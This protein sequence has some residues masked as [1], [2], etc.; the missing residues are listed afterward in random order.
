MW[1]GD[2]VWVGRRTGLCGVLAT[3]IISL[4]FTSSA[5]AAPASGAKPYSNSKVEG[6]LAVGALGVLSAALIPDDQS[7]G[8][9]TVNDPTVT[10]AT[11]VPGQAVT[12]RDTATD[13]N[14]TNGTYLTYTWDFGDGTPDVTTT[15]AISSVS[16]TFATTGTYTVTVNVSDS[17]DGGDEVDAAP[18]PCGGGGGCGG[19]DN[20]DGDTL[21]V[22]V[23]TA[24]TGDG[25]A[26]NDLP[27][28]YANSLAPNDDGYSDDAVPIGFPINFFGETET[29]LYVNENGNVTFD[30]QQSAFSP[31]PL[32]T[33]DQPIIAPFWSDVDTSDPVTPDG[34]VSSL[35]TYGQT[36]YDGNPAFCV[37]WGGENGAVGYYDQH[38][39]K[40]NRYELLIVDR[41]DVA[42]GD[43]DIYFN[44]DQLQYETGDASGG[45]D[46]LGGDGARA[47]YANG[48][49]SYELPGSGSDGVFLTGDPDDLVANSNDGVAGQYVYPFRGGNGL[50]STTL[51]GTVTDS[52][53][54]DVE[55][56]VEA[57]PTGGGACDTAWSNADGSYSIDAQP[58]TAYTVTAYPL[59]NDTSDS[60]SAAT[61]VTTPSAGDIEQELQLEAPLLPPTNVTIQSS[62]TATQGGVPVVDWQDST[63]LTVVGCAGGSASYSITAVNPYDGES[64]TVTGALTPGAVSG[65][66]TTYSASIPQLYPLHG[67]AQVTIT[68]TGCADP[69]ADQ[70]SAFDIYIDPSGMVVNTSGQPIADATVTLLTASSAAGP[71]YPVP[72][73]SAVMSP[74]NRVNPFTTDATGSYGWDTLAG[75]YEVEATAPGCYAPGNPSSP[76]VYS[77]VL[78]VPPAATGVTLTLDCAPLPPSTPA[79]APAPTPTP[80]TTASV[81]SPTVL[82]GRL[83]NQEL[84]ASFAA[85][86]YLPTSKLSLAFSTTSVSGVKPVLKFKRATVWIDKGVK[87]IKVVTELIHGKHKKVKRTTYVANSTIA[88][89]SSTA[90]VSLRGLTAGTHTI[91]VIA[92]YTESV[93]AKKG[94]RTVTETKTLTK[95]LTGHVT[96]S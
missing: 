63:P 96:V 42:A 48:E 82:S 46:G 84:S 21:F 90:S 29:S 92:T 9:I 35:V 8:T 44:Y 43:F 15:G 70:N 23:V 5:L 94:H 2:L 76:A 89:A 51:Y 20:G 56:E 33:E 14:D 93:K 91:K 54:D 12:F 55:A 22:N 10:S 11:P 64:G 60:P 66:S 53:N 88:S 52:N 4:A 80:A 18:D 85:G 24:L 1:A 6:N 13:I 87:T 27:G 75:N 30:D 16:H 59:T 38:T 50:A 78:T 77:Q 28:C 95:T 83:G 61:P 49:N 67:S 47:G 74:D 45:V 31:Y 17:A 65:D 72:N 58:S 69:T 40:L 73:G 34:P 81:P 41:P 36:T 7:D 25:S 19:A 86:T 39:D 37:I 79:P 32:S 71:F 57:C 3:A 62:D 68:V 26:V